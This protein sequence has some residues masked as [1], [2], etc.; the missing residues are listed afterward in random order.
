MTVQFE[1]PATFDINAA[2]SMAETIFRYQRES[3]SVVLFHRPVPGG[4]LRDVTAGEFAAQVVAVAKGL[5]ASGIQ[6]GDRVALMSGTRY[7]W[8]LLD[9]AIWTVGGCTVAIYDSS[10]ADQ[11]KWILEDSGTS[12]LVVETRR[13]HE[14]VKQIAATAS[15][16]RETLQIEAG[17][18][19]ELIARG[20]GV[21]EAE[22][23]AR[24]RAVA[25]GSPATLIYTS[26]T[27]GRPKGAQLTHANLYAESAAVR[28]VLSS[29]LTPGARTLLFLPL[30][31]VFAR[32]ISI[33]AVDSGTTVAHT[34]DWTTLV[35]QFA[36]YGPD[37][38]LAVPRVLE[39]VYGSA[40]QQAR[41][42]GKGRIFDRAADTAVA[43]S[44]AWDTGGPGLR[45]RIEH[46]VFDRLVYR[47]LRAALGGR[48]RAVVSGGGPL[49][50]HLGHFFRGL[51]VAVY[52]GYGLTETTAAVSVNAP[53]QV[54]LGTVGRPLPGHTIR[55]ADDG[56]LLVRGPV[57]A[58]GYWHN[59]DA[60]RDAFVESWFKTG[61]LATIDDDGYVTITGRKKEIIVTAAGKNVSPGQLED[62]LRT[63]PLISQCLVVGDG[64][65]FIAALI[66]VDPEALD[67]WKHRHGVPADTPLAE[68]VGEPR[69]VA[70]IQ[71]AVTAANQRFSRAEQIKKIRVL[72]VDW[73]Q[74][75]GE[76]TPKLSLKRDVVAQKFAADIE[77]L[78]SA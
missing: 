46:T 39:K 54:R 8:V 52:E 38:I 71:R 49:G 7:E 68:L 34:S 76:L 23:R 20:V 31:H 24:H 77:T 6:P 65:P 15:D 41:D 26:G 45:L 30:A 12:L 19:E 37:F 70:D 42:A 32:V 5:I 78:Y 28:S 10:A 61:D 75:T 64:K 56:E 27:T 2:T 11:A 51:G 25:A 29:M 66:T 48:C 21:N 50:A 16:L 18:I 40:E 55:I 17:A 67:N 33:A 22:V 59:P 35:D 60:T 63:D 62:A 14:T 57:V 9:Y 13:H 58:D 69:L 74:E 43:W 73:T 72:D 36:D 44:R 47:K 53:D 1:V 4:R 3:P